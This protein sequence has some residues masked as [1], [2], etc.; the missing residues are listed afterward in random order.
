MYHFLVHDY[1]K[2]KRW[3]TLFFHRLKLKIDA[4]LTYAR[5]PEVDFLHS[6]AVILNKFLGKSS[7]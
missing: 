4:F 5:Q 7:L 3:P 1:V 6:S 2:L